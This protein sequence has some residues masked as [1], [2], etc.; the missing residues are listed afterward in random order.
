MQIVKSYKPEAHRIELSLD[1]NKHEFVNN[2][3]DKNIDFSK[4]NDSL[5]GVKTVLFDDE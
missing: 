5:Y 3:N 4:D 2:A 1:E